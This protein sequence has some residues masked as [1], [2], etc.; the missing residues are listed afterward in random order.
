MYKAKLWDEDKWDIHSNSYGSK[1]NFTEDKK[2]NEQKYGSKEKGIG[3]D[4][5]RREEDKDKEEKTGILEDL[6]EEKKEVEEKEIKEEDIPLKAAKEIFSESKHEPKIEQ[7]KD[8]KT[9]EDAIK[10]A[11]EEERKVIV[12]D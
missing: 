9:I 6:E 12:M 4:Y 5:M 11:I 1:H 3:S 7:K 10:K 8:I 2:Y